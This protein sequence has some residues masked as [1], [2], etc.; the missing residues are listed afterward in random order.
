MFVKPTS[1]KFVYLVMPTSTH[2][3]VYLCIV[4]F[5]SFKDTIKCVTPASTHKFVYLCIVNLASSKDTISLYRQLPPI[6][7]CN[8]ALYSCRL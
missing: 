1:H 5:V 6:N 7:L 2:K 8:F 3:L 4:N